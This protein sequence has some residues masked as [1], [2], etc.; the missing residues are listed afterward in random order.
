MERSSVDVHSQNRE[1]NTGKSDPAR[2]FSYIPV[3]KNSFQKQITRT[4]LMLNCPPQSPLSFIAYYGANYYRIVHALQFGSKNAR[5]LHLLIK[6]KTKQSGGG[7]IFL[8]FYQK[9]KI[10][11]LLVHDLCA[12]MRFHV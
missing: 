11:K 1:S 5:V 10:S 3:E 9:K 6:V 4:Y 7:Q 12:K 2:T 8:L